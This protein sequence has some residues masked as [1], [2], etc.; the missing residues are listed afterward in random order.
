[1]VSVYCDHP[2]ICDLSLSDQRCLSSGGYLNACPG[3]FE[4]G[5]C[6][7]ST[8]VPKEQRHAPWLDAERVKK[9]DEIMG[10]NTRATYAPRD[11][12]VDTETG[13]IT[14]ENWHWVRKTCRSWGEAIETAFRERRR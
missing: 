8:Y 13:E 11:M 10:E 5:G 12:Y 14:G 1:M 3:Y 6:P 2:T 9:H 4:T 7:P